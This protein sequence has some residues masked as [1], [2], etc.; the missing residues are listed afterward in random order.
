[1]A[2]Y[3][4]KCT[5]CGALDDSASWESAEKAADDGVFSQP[6]TC[7]T[8][9]WTEFDLVQAADSTTTGD[10][11]G[12]HKDVEHA[13]VAASDSDDMSINAPNFRTPA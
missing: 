9:A 5:S 2:N 13:Q 10:I 12:K 8:C 4:R 11:S 1:M 7:A 3:V 6:W